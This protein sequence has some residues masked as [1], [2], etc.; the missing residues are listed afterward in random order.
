[1]TAPP[2]FEVRNV[3]FA[4]G[5]S[6][7]RHWHGGRAST[8]AFL[9]NL[10]VF[11]PEGEAF[12]VR[13]VRAFRHL[14]AQDPELSRAVR[15]FCGQEGVH[16]REHRAYNSMVGA[17]GYPVAELERKVGRL[18]GL[19]R[20]RTYRR[21]QLAVTAA[22]EHFTALMAHAILSDERVFADADPVMRDLWLWH[23]AEENEHKAVAYD[24][25]LLAGGNY[26]ERVAVM[27]GVTFVFWLKV[28]EHQVRFMRV[29]GNAASAAAWG[30]LLHYL[31]VAP[32]PLRRIVPHYL[33][34]FVPGFH[35]WDLD[36]R[37]LLET[38]KEHFRS[39]PTHA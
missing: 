2:Q 27:V 30:E 4:F 36:N 33:A 14:A 23:A 6:I 1:M 19:V 39:S 11:F 17:K 5:E 38:W 3:H 9:D 18:L 37:D 32:G 28:L 15:D 29:D 8:T 22:L 16:S 25:Y 10:S 7:P 20:R 24:L 13:S 34:W 21:F 26:P 31:Y 35:P 12:F